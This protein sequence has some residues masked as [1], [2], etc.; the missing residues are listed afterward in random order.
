MPSA[1]DTHAIVQAIDAW[2]ATLPPGA[3]R[4]RT[5]DIPADDE[6]GFDTLFSIEPVKPEACPIEIGVTVPDAGSTVGMFLDRWHNVAQRLHAE[7]SPDKA[8]RVALFVEPRAMAIA[9]VIDACAAVVAGNVRLDAGLFRQ[10]LIA[11]NGWL[12]T[13]GGRFKMRGVE[14]YLVPFLRTMTAVGIV[15]VQTL[16]YQPWV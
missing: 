10:T 16:A 13:R 7:V 3:F 4:K 9:Q 6:Y 5:L 15:K 14:D 8:N 2:L 11:T 12:D 1:R